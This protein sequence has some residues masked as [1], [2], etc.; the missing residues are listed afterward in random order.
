MLK[1]NKVKLE[2]K[3]PVYDLLNVEDNSNFVC[4]GAVVSNCTEITLHSD[5]EHT[6]TCQPKFASL[7]KQGVGLTTLEHV[8]PN[9]IIWSKGGWTKVTHKISSGIKPV[10]EYFTCSGIFV[11]TEDHRVLQN[12]QKIQVNHAVFIDQCISPPLNLSEQNISELKELYLNYGTIDDQFQVHFQT[13]DKEAYQIFYFLSSLGFSPRIYYIDSQTDRSYYDVIIS[14]NKDI[15]QIQQAIEGLETYSNKN[16]IFRYSHCD[17]GV[18]KDKISL[19]D[20]EVFHIE[21][22]HPSHTYWT[23]GLDVSNCVL[24]SLNLS[25]YDEWKDTDTIFDSTVF[26]DCVASEFISLGND[27]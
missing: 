16:H 13:K 25:K 22:D 3:E 10:Y 27:I 18:I 17:V 20:H 11:G 7:I 4:N 23:G 5:E 8:N 15:L 19:G 9:D 14:L 21:V 2:K 26:L 12:Q 24:S 6:Y 1:I